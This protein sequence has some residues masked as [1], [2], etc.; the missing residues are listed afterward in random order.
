[1][2]MPERPVNVKLIGV[3]AEDADLGDIGSVEIRCQKPKAVTITALQRR[4][5]PGIG[6]TCLPE[7]EKPE[8]RSASMFELNEVSE[9]RLIDKEL[10]VLARE[11]SFLP[12]V[13]ATVSALQALASSSKTATGNKK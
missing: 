2:I 3:K 8:E 12:A 10:E 9:E 13:T 5:M 1:M 4:G 11:A 7:G 6:V